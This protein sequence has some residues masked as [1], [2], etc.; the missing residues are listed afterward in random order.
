M[1]ARLDIRTERLAH[2]CSV[3]SG[4]RSASEMQSCWLD[5]SKRRNPGAQLSFRARKIRAK[6]YRI[7]IVKKV[8]WWRQI[9][10][11]LGTVLVTVLGMPGPPNLAGTLV[12]SIQTDS[13][14]FWAVSGNL[15][16][17]FIF[18]H[19][20]HFMNQGPIFGLPMT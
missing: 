12:T 20:V 17:L 15:K 10:T 9:G 7:K 4:A 8:A 5:N 16:I 1:R 13:T 11:V 19:S 14:S 18:V 2:T 3:P 6:S